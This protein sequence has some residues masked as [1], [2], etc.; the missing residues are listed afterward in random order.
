MRQESGNIKSYCVCISVT[1]LKCLMEMVK[2]AEKELAE[3]NDKLVKRV[4]RVELMT[5]DNDIFG[6]KKDKPTGKV[7]RANKAYVLFT[8]LS[9]PP[10]LN[11]D[12]VQNYKASFKQSKVKNLLRQ[13]LLSMNSVQ[14]YPEYHN[15]NHLEDFFSC[16]Y[17]SNESAALYSI[18]NIPLELKL[19]Y[20][21][22]LSRK[23]KLKQVAIELYDETKK[24]LDMFRNNWS[25]FKDC[26]L[27]AINSINFQTNK[28]SAKEDLIRDEAKRRKL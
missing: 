26:Y 9:M 21:Q 12:Y 16:L 18:D 19:E 7:Y 4:Q 20:L 23:E 27:R 25:S 11:F 10:H 22:V 15:G 28:L 24:R 2:G 6:D 8:E 13:V 3:V 17:F 14:V 5:Q 1:D